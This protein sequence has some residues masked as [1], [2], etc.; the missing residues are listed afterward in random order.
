MEDLR[1][2]L[3]LFKG[4]LHFLHLPQIRFFIENNLRLIDQFLSC[5]RVPWG[6]TL[7]SIIISQFFP[8]YH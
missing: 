6:Y 4:F 7:S 8:K 5:L 1:P 2:I 3:A